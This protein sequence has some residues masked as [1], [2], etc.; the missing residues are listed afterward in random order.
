VREALKLVLAK[1]YRLVL[2]N[3]LFA[4]YYWY[5]LSSISGPCYGAEKLSTTACGK[6]L[7]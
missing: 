4:V 5:C 2:P 6:G 1:L 3:N 7:P